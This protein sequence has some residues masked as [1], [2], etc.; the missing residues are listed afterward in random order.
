MDLDNII[1]FLK[2]VDEI[3]TARMLLDTLA[4]YSNTVQQLD[5]LGKN[6]CEIKQYSD[7]AK[8]AL[9]ALT[10]APDNQ[11]L[12]SIRANLAKLYNHMNDP[13]QALFYLKLN[14]IVTPNDPE[15]LLEQTFSY[16][17]LNE[18]QKSEDIL[19]EMVKR[20]DIS[21]Q[22]MNR[23]KFNLG[24]YDLYHGEFQ[25]GL[26]G[27]ILEGKK[28]DIWKSVNLPFTF[29]DG[30]IVI[31][32]TIIIVAEGGI[33][34]EIISVRFM[35]QLKD[36]G[37]NPIW[38]TTRKDI[39]NIFNR[40]GYTAITTLGAVPK[41]SLWTY[42]M[43]LPIYLDLQPT[44][45]W[46]GQ[47]LQVSDQY[48]EKWSW[49][50]SNNSNKIKV[51]IRWSGNP[52]YE[53]DLHRSVPLNQLYNAIK[54]KGYEIYSL[55]RDEGADDINQFPEIIDLQHKLV[56]YEDT[57]AAM[58]NLDIIITSCTSVLHVAAAMN[59]R[60]YGLIPTT[61]YYTWCSQDEYHSQWYSEQLTLFRQ[62]KLRD[63][64]QPIQQLT[65]ALNKKWGMS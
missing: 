54:D 63:W 46:S 43:S 29:W 45:L 2:N 21:E 36:F 64:T 3:K 28:L 56:S 11:S 31:G 15:V 60:V 42:S 51:G 44:D 39:A 30:G 33:G 55:Q 62:K 49:M 25:K 58:N 59:K 20:T 40:H 41:D 6:Y 26:K 32:K 61:A 9:K 35:K 7:A 52:A 47:Y 24:T 65:D 16:F 12:Y 37:M 1:T 14:E 27:F 23:V 50:K 22:V 48:K 10:I 13:E 19:R 53:H 17:L 8:W 57:M 5:A 4:K 18:K 38:Y 34:D